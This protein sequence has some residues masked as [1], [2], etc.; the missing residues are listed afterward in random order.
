MGMEIYSQKLRKWGRQKPVVSASMDEK[1]ENIQEVFK[2]TY[3]ELYNS[4]D[5]K[6]SLQ[7][8]SDEVNDSLTPVSYTHLTLPTNR[9]V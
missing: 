5:D 6:L 7:L 2:E 1:T 9:E 3:A 8:L 4:V